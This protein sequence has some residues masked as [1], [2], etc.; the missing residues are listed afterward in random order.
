M[1]KNDILK[2]VC[3]IVSEHLDLPLKE[4]K[5]KVDTPFLDYGEL[6]DSPI[7]DEFDFMELMLAFEDEFCIEIPEE[8]EDKV[9]TIND[10]ADYILT[11]EVVEYEDGEEFD[12]SD[13]LPEEFKA[14]SNEVKKQ[15]QDEMYKTWVKKL[16]KEEADKMAAQ[17]FE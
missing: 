16:G 9:T 14:K 13:D 2:R 1:E 11:A 7:C 5:K 6:D 10:V 12:E 4:V 17:F 15:M 8:D 3:E